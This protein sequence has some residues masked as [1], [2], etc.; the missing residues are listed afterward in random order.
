MAEIF[1]VPEGEEQVCDHETRPTG[2][3]DEHD[4]RITKC[5][6]C[7]KEFVT[8]CEGRRKRRRKDKD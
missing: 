3:Y 2:E 8:I 1:I 7:D 6:H 4:R 5:I